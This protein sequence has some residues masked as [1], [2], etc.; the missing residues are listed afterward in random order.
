MMH[1]LHYGDEARGQAWSAV[2]KAEVPE[3]DFRCWPDLGD[4]AEVRALVAWT[5]T[6]ELIAL[7]PNLEILF[8]IGAGID[9]LDVGKLPPHLRIVRM[10]EPG[11]TRTMADY[12]AM[13]V[14]ALHRDLPF[15]LA[16][17]R[18]GRWS[19][20]E[21]LLTSERRI[22]MM[23]LGELG[24]AALAALAPHGFRLSGW[25]RTARAIDG[26]TGFSGPKG[27]DAFLGQSDILVCLL[28]LTDETRGILCR[29]TFAKLPWGCP[30]D[31]RG[32]RRAS[33]AGR[34]A[35]GAGQRPAGGGDARCDRSRTAP[36]GPSVLPPPGN[37]PHPAHLRRHPQGNGSACP[38][39]QSAARNR[40]SAAAR[41]SRSCSRLLT[42][43]RLC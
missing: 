20:R 8:S 33:G 3:I 22:G 40:R 32:A 31:Q 29:E 24:R 13:A 15:Y 36:A 41:R 25:S 28:P 11:I 12:V 38:D 2:F 4:P 27:L 16:E 30:T 1:V 18:A 26:V 23:G 21:T 39:R 10:I 34:S 35:G 6:N 14:L 9:Q 5:L 7:L 19:H 43:G 37:C 42:R 17:Q